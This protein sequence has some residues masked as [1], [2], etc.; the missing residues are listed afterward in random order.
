MTFHGSAPLCRDSRH[1]HNRRPSCSLAAA[2]VLACLAA[3]PANA[4]AILTGDAAVLGS[5]LYVGDTV[6]GSLLV[7]GGSVLDGTV[8]SPPIPAFNQVIIG[9]SSAG[10]GSVT[11]DGA[12]SK[13]ITSGPSSL[14]GIMVGQAGVGTLAVTNGAAVTTQ[15]VRSAAQVGSSASI[16]VSDGSSLQGAGVFNVADGGSATM[17]ISGASKVNAQTMLLGTNAGGNGRL[18]VTG[19]GSA[20]DLV[21]GSSPATSRAFLGVGA[22]QTGR[23]DI[24]AGAKVTLD[25]APSSAGGGSFGVNVGGGNAGA[26]FAGSH[27]TLVIDGS[28]SELRLKGT[29]PSAQIGRTG[30]GTMSIT[31][32]AKFIVEDTT[33][34]NSVA[35]VG[36]AI[37]STGIANVI[38]SGSEWQAGRRLRI[39]EESGGAAGGTG[40]VN[41]ADGGVIRAPLITVGRASPVTGGGG[42]LTGN[43]TLI[44]NLTNQGVIAPGSSPGAMSVLGNI[45]L[46]ADGLVRI[47]LAGTDVALGQHDQLNA[48]DN[49]GTTTTEGRIT[50]GGRIDIDLLHDYMPTAGSFFDIFTG[51]DIVDGTVAYDLP[52]LAAGLSWSHSLIDLDGGREALRLSVTGAAVPIPGTLALLL[53]GLLAIRLGGRPVRALQHL[54]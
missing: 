4:G 36:R 3:P 33:S 47:E 12:G 17:T 42:T 52:A 19:I 41:V 46:A 31:N 40:T 35:S 1:E 10:N 32:G 29:D 26:A 43:G 54:I 51:L 39:G 6:T 27:G 5:Q 14:V 13:L 25:A 45:T 20:L 53:G 48:Y 21:T 37:G 28:G 38:G 30:F 23:L 18:T 15:H 2:A 24:L 7:N 9:A 22:T 50:L 8:G 16:I 11:V 49:P 34:I 44:G